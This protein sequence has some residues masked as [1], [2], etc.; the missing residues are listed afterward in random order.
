MA[1]S[2]QHLLSEGNIGSMTLKNR[3]V[4]AAMGANF[5]EL[6]GRSG[7]RVRAYHEAQ[8]AGGVGL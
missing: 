5:G 3:M 7:D 8:A 2:H 4:V 1:Q 6:D